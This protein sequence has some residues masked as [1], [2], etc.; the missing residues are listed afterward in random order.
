MSELSRR[1]LFLPIAPVAGTLEVR[2]GLSFAA[3]SVEFLKAGRIS[4]SLTVIKPA[5]T[6]GL[7]TVERIVLLVGCKIFAVD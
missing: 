2:A 3:G 7:S 5:M 4:V 1:P 6:A